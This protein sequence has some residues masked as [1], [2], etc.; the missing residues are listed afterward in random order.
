[1][2]MS[3][4]LIEIVLFYYHCHHIFYFSLKVFRHLRPAILM[5]ADGNKTYAG[6]TI[7]KPI[8]QLKSNA[9]SYVWSVVVCNVV[10][11]QHE[12]FTLTHA[13]L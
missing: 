4:V 11:L 13:E 3:I 9:V 1:M 7:P 5:L 8:Q 2:R 6:S 10:Y 12:I